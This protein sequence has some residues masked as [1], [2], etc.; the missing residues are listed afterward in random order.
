MSVNQYLNVG[1]GQKRS[2]SHGR[3]HAVQRQ[4]AEPPLVRIAHCA[5]DFCVGE[6]ARYFCGDVACWDVDYGGVAGEEVSESGVYKG[7]VFA[8][9]DAED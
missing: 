2:H 1:T 5:D 3:Y 4:Y 7:V 8:G 6:G 9:R